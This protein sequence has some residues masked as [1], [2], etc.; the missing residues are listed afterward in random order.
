MAAQESPIRIN[1]RL[2]AQA[3]AAAETFHRKAPEQISYWADIGRILESR[4]NAT[5]ISALL[6]GIAEI[7][8][9]LP[10]LSQKPDTSGELDIVALA[11]SHQN[12]EGFKKAEAFIAQRSPGV[13]YQASAAQPGLLERLSPDGSVAYGTF[14]NGKFKKSTTRTP[15]GA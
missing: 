10:A 1:A 8:V 12:A 2:L 15:A 6:S 7:H 14:K 13:R 5:E 11:M 4:L 3:Q 9:S